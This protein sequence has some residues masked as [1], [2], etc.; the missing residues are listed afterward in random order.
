MEMQL[1]GHGLIVDGVRCLTA[2][3]LVH[4]RMPLGRI[5][6]FWP[7]ATR[8]HPRAVRALTARLMHLA[9]GRM[10]PGLPMIGCAGPVPR[11]T[12]LNL[13]TGA[14]VS[15]HGYLHA[16]GM[17]ERGRTMP[18]PVYFLDILPMPDPHRSVS[19]NEGTR[20]GAPPEAPTPS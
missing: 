12:T 5:T 4:V 9:A 2:R 13:Q 15:W 7:C 10:P 8:N 11:W 17:E 20:L 18:H 14:E 3:R 16:F 6:I 19:T 1:T